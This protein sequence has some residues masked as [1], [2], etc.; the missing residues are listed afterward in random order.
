[1]IRQPP[2]ST[3][4]DARFPYTPPFRSL[5]QANRVEI[6]QFEIGPIVKLFVLGPFA[7]GQA[8]PKRWIDI[9]GDFASGAGD[10]GLANPRSE[11]MVGVD[12]Q[13]ITLGLA[14]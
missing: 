12:V 6:C 2:R 5:S 7:G 3:R 4:T 9:S 8:F 10:L 13:H 1:M 11:V 14:T